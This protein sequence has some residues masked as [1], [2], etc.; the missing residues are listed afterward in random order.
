M[1]SGCS[2]GIKAM[3]PWAPERLATMTPAERGAVFRDLQHKE[4]R[5]HLEAELRKKRLSDMQAVATRLDERR[6]GGRQ[7][8]ESESVSEERVS[9][10][11]VFSEDYDEE[12]ESVDLGTENASVK[13]G[14][15]PSRRRSRGVGTATASAGSSESIGVDDADISAAVQDGKG[16]SRRARLEED[17]AQCGDLEGKVKDL[18]EQLGV[19]REVVGMCGQPSD[20]T[21]EE[22]K[23]KS[24]KDKVIS[25]YFGASAVGNERSRLRAEV[26]ALRKA[27]DFLFHKL[28]P[29]ETQNN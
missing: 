2:V 28:Q 15:R 21:V 20:K 13:S 18:E 14:D 19:L 5:G 1:C 24:W 29:H 11:K 22:K 6:A 17:C 4:E 27:T 25:A 7:E 23:P 26:E 9:D 16:K 8:L 3:P 10:G 12:L